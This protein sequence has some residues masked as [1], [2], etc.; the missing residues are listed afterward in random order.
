MKKFL[1]AAL[2]AAFTF[3][4]VA[5]PA[6]SAKAQ[7]VKLTTK[8]AITTADTITF[9]NVGSKVKAFQYTFTETSGTTAG[10]IILEG[11]INGTWKGVDSVALTDIT[12][13]QTL[14]TPVTSTI[15]SSYRFRCTNTSSATGAVK[16]AYIRRTDE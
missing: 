7:T 13:A 2:V 5:I 14:V 1:F 11:T 4:S 8:A 9:S 16:A 3:G 12:A 15:Y 10:K 6:D